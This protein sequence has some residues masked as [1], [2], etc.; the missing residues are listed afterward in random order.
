MAGRTSYRVMDLPWTLEARQEAR[1]R[2]FV[3]GSVLL[4]TLLAVLLSWV[5][6]PEISIGEVREETTRYATLL[7]DEAEAEIPTAPEPEPE[8]QPEPIVEP[9]PELQPE[10]EPEPI[11]EPEP[12]VEPEPEPEPEPIV[13]PEPEPQPEPEPEPEPRP[14]PEPEPQVVI[15]PPPPPPP[16]PVDP[17]QAA[18]ERAA[19][20]GL[21]AAA[22]ALSDLQRSDSNQPTR[23]GRPLTR[24]ADISDSN[25]TVPTRPTSISSQRINSTSGSVSER[26]APSAVTARS[27]N[28]RTR[29]STRVQASRNPAIAAAEEARQ[30]AAG[31]ERA[32][33]TDAEIRLVVERNKGRFERLHKMALRQNPDALGQVLMRFT[34]APS[35]EVTSAQIV[36]SSMNDPAFDRRILTLFRQLDFG[37]KNV[38]TVTKEYRLNFLQ[39]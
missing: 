9:E 27:E 13:E 4:F 17:R 36:D 22:D 20:S 23:Q 3:L 12:V 8:A 31:A 35:G 16:P 11:V 18:R 15:S 19:N 33:R 21:F 34:I 6:A 38:P 7:L 14:T 37:A 32:G 1:F 28:L 5:R 25:S 29:E 2:W 30:S 39:G 10:P 26:P 24:S